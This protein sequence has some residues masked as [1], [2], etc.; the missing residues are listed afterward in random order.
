MN[1]EHREEFNEDI[2]DMKER[3]Q[4]KNLSKRE[5]LPT[6]IWRSLWQI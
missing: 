1:D 5:Y 6:N 4:G 2:A 3:H